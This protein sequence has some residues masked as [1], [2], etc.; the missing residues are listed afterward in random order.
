M[1]QEDLRSIIYGGKV[2]LPKT[3]EGVQEIVKKEKRIDIVKGEIILSLEKLDKILEI[4]EE[5]K[6]A[7]VEAGVILKELKE[8]LGKRKL[9]FPV[10]YDE[11]KTIGE[12]L[13]TN[14]LANR[15]FRYGRAGDWVKELYIIDADGQLIKVNRTDFTDFIGMEGTTGVIVKAR[16]KLISRVKRTATLLKIK[17]E[18]L[19][20]LK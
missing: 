18:K 14:V 16:L 4:D 19:L 10:D 2:F 7:Y 13:A 8:E 6:E 9:E 15:G 5:K 1:K 11:T 3:I 17:L 20:F 12:I